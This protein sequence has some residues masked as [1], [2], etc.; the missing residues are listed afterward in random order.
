MQAL[1]VDVFYNIVDVAINQLELRFE[2]QR[3]VADLFKFLF[4]DTMLKLSDAELE[5]EAQS[6]QMAYSADLGEDLIS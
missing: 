3:H 2:G 4:P 5:T 1:K 6:L